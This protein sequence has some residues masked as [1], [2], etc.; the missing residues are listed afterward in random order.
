MSTAKRLLINRTSLVL[1]CDEEGH[2]LRPG[3]RRVVL[4]SDSVAQ[5]RV[6]AGQFFWYGDVIDPDPEPEAPEPEPEPAAEPEP[7]PEKVTTTR[8]RTAKTEPATEPPAN[9]E[10]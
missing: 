7:E 2:H 6:A 9:E 5:R 3:G 8:K 10:K 4:L 1:D